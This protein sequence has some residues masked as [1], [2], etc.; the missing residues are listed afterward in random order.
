MLEIAPVTFCSTCVVRNSLHPASDECQV[1][2][3]VVQVVDQ[4]RVAAGKHFALRRDNGIDDGDIVDLA[5]VGNCRDV[6]RDGN[7]RHRRHRLPD[8]GQNR[9][10]TAPL[11][12]VDVVVGVRNDGVGIHHR[13]GHVQLFHQDGAHVF[14]PRGFGIRHC[15]VHQ[16]LCA[17]RQALIVVFHAA[18]F[19]ALLQV[20]LDGVENDN[21]ARRVLR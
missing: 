12:I 2:V 6:A 19:A 14:N 10:R 18:R 20:R 16:A 3:C 7:R 11:N 1:A 13:T 8:G 15:H 17:V 5:A 21:R 9:L 4:H